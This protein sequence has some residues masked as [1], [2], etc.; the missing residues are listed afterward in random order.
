MD[1]LAERIN[2]IELCK[3]SVFK[4]KNGIK[5]PY[6]IIHYY[7]GTIRRINSLD[8]NEYLMKYVIEND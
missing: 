4:T 6:L 7:D 8:L 1:K 5:Y 2:K 3:E